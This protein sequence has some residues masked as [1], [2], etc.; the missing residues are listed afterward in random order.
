MRLFVGVT[1][2]EWF[3]LHASKK[4]IDEGIRLKITTT[5]QC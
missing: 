2:Y 4:Q 5:S 3:Q 1:D